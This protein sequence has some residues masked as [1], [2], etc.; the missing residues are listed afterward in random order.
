MTSLFM[1][2]MVFGRPLIW[3]RPRTSMARSSS[4]G[5]AEPNGYFDL[6]GGL[7]ADQEVI[8]FADVVDDGFVE[9]VAADAHAAPDDDVVHGDDSGF[10][11]AAAHIDDHVSGGG[12]DREA[13]AV[14]CG[15]GFGDEVGCAGAGLHGG[16]VDGAFLGRR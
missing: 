12:A 6:F 4:V 1:I 16:V 10:G 7:F 11:G 14:G 2:S 9:A 13:G 3:S 15:E 5:R 8:F